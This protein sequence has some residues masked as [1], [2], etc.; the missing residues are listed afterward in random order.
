MSPD[1][2]VHQGRGR[3]DTANPELLRG[4][5]PDKLELCVENPAR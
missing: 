2:R 3:L 4:G 1:V 5:I